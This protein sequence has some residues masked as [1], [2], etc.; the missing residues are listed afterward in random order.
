MKDNLALAVNID[1]FMRL[2]HSNLHPKASV[3]DRDNVGP[4]GGM[5]LMTIADQQPIAIQQLTHYLGR[6][7]SQMTRLLRTLEDKKLLRR[8]QSEID[9]RVSLVSLTKRGEQLV[10]AFQSELTDVIEE[11]TVE[12]TATQRDQLSKLIQKVLQSAASD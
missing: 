12:L 9:A 3:V 1:R 5:V 4:F 10:G 8:E 7:K 11:L 2:I 6:D